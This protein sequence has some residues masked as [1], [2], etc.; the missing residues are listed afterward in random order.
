MWVGSVSIKC[1]PACFHTTMISAL[2]LQMQRHLDEA[3]A[4]DG[5]CERAQMSNRRNC[6]SYRR[7]GKARGRRVTESVEIN[8]IVGNIEARVIEDIEGVHVVPQRKSFRQL[9][10]LEGA[11]IETVL[12]GTAED[13]APARRV[14]VLKRVAGAGGWIARRHAVGPRREGW[15]RTKRQRIQNRLSSIYTGRALKVRVG[16]GGP[17]AANRD[18]GIRRQVLA[19]TPIDAGDASAVVNHAIR[20]AAL[21]DRDPIESPPIYDLLHPS[22]GVSQGWELIVVTHGEHVGAVEVRV[23]VRR[24][25]IIGVVATVEKSQTALLVERVRIGV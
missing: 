12:E 2:K 3:W 21:Q 4:A 7:A 6:I 16:R 8:A 24:A 17:N 9:E 14:T 23:S 1:Q 15:H 5:V 20:L 11:E 22:V 18:D 19:A 10:I 13:V 25:R